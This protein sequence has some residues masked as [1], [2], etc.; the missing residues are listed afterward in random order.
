MCGNEYFFGQFPVDLET[1]DLSVNHAE[2]LT[3]LAAMERFGPRLRGRRL[4][5]DGDNMVSVGAHNKLESKEPAMDE[6]ARGGQRA[7]LRHSF[8]A[9][10]TYV[11]TDAMLAD[12]LSRLQEEEFLREYAAAGRV[13][14][15]GPAKRVAP[16]LAW[17]SRWLRRLASIK[18]AAVQRDAARVAAWSKQP[19]RGRPSGH[20]GP[21]PRDRHGWP[22]PKAWRDPAPD[23][24][25]RH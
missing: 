22:I 21:E 12:A 16:P 11:P 15:F 17:L 19:R 4:I 20:H 9:R 8:S 3:T 24:A 2:G 25:K 5:F 18:A 13:E 14:R 1:L 6:I 23:A 10:N 7:Q